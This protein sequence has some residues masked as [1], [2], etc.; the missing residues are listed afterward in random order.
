MLPKGKLQSIFKDRSILIKGMP[1][2]KVWEWDE[3]SFSELAPLWAFVEVQG[4]VHPGISRKSKKN[5]AHH[6]GRS[7]DMVDRDRKG[8]KTIQM[9]TR[10]RMIDVVRAVKERRRLNVLDLPQGHRDLAHMAGYA[11]VAM[12]S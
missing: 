8:A 2:E 9:N 1:L 3:L 11:Y 5:I 10:V 4:S 12:S 7:A 6:R